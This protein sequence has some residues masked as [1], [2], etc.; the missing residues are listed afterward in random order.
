MDIRVKSIVDTVQDAYSELSGR[1]RLVADF[2]L[3]A[4]GEVGA[5]GASELARLVGVSPST[6]TRFVKRIGFARYEQMRRAARDARA[7]GSPLYIAPHM[8]AADPGTT[9]ASIGRFFDHEMSV[10]QATRDGFAPG[11]L[12]D[13]ARTLNRARKLYFMGF[14]NSYFFAAYAQWQF[15]QFRANTW[16]MP[17]AGETMAERIADLGE[18]DV[19][20]VIGVRRVVAE[21]EGLIKAV[22][23]TLA[24]LAPITD[25]SAR[26]A[27]PG[28]RWTIT[29]EVE[30]PGVFDSYSGTL[31]VIRFLAFQT[32]L[33]SGKA[34]RK[35]MQRIEA[36]HEELAEFA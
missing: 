16:L 18:G 12:E 22:A 11:E 32:F 21:M 3:G 10:L 27:C 30:N 9:G 19:V 2:I 13:L 20:L 35:R 25:P 1:E 34:G 7:W 14:R 4:P 26:I 23:D 28:A 29:C 33:N 24:D 6:V 15:I 8:P 31:A 36:C 5:Y 17:Q